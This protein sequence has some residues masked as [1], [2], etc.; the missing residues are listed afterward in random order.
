MTALYS[1]PPSLTH[2]PFSR[3]T[4]LTAVAIVP[5]S[6]ADATGVRSPSASSAP[7]AV[8]AAPAAVAWRFPGR[9]PTLSKNW[10]VPSMP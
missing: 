10:P 5:M 7:P 8:S 2:G 3:W 6:A 4:V 9:S 1:Q